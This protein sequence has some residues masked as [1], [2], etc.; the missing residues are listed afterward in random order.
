M[1]PDRLKYGFFAVLLG[2]K[3][4]SNVATPKTFA[5]QFPMPDTV[6]LIT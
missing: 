5:Q 6:F 2:P 3:C 4:S 1:F